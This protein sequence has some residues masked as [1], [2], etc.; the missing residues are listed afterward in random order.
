VFRPAVIISSENSAL[1]REIAL[2]LQQSGCSTHQMSDCA[3]TQQA[4]AGKPPDQV[5]A[6]FGNDED[7][8][9]GS[10][11]LDGVATALG[12]ETLKSLQAAI[13]NHFGKR[14]APVRVAPGPVGLLGGERLIGET[15]P[16]RQLRDSIERISASNSNVLITGE[17]GTGKDLIAELIQRNGPRR[18]K[19]FVCI[20]CAAIP[21]NLFESEL[22]GYERGAFTGAHQS[23]A[24]KLEQA[25]GETLFFD[26][27]GDM[28][29]CAQAKIL[30]AIESKEIQRLGGRRNIK[31]DVRI[32]AATNRELDSP[33]G[34]LAFR[35]D[36]YFRLNVASIHLTPLRER[37]ADI[38]LLVH[39]YIG[40]LNQRFGR[41]VAGLAPD[42]LPHLLQYQW[43]GNVRELKNMLESTFVNLGAGH[44]EWMQLPEPLRRC[45]MGMGAL[46]PS[47]QELLLNALWSTGWNKSK[48]ARQLQWSRMTVYRKMAKYHLI[49]GEEHATRS[50]AS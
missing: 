28:S 37:T 34:K 24:G 46:A 2:I 16:I 18:A 5:L 7:C 3:G 20:N 30:R 50:A 9:P 41:S 17:T 26:E 14:A 36:L 45:I 21:E 27:I 8:P 13:E 42:I 29:S 40:E 23:Q 47:E 38:P 31:V 32:I 35:R 33:E 10:A 25:D 22:F 48:V 1:R 39:Y 12:D 49:P 43:P 11:K 15:P 4:L 44:V 6:F 19:S